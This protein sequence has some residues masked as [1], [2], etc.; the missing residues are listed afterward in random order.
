M[1][2]SLRFSILGPLAVEQDGAPIAI[3]GRRQRALLLRLLLARGR[4]VAASRLI[5]DLWGGEP[6][7]SATNTLQTYVSLLRRAFGDK[8]QAVLVRDA[9]GYRLALEPGALDIDRF[10]ELVRRAEK[11]P[12][13]EALA[14]L[15]EALGLWHGPALLDVADE[16]YAQA[17]SVRL[18]E[19]RLAAVEGR[20][21]RLLD[22]GRHAEAVPG[23]EAA[24][25]EQ[26]LR[27][28]LT[29]LLAQALYRSGRQADALRAI[30]RT[31]THLADEL[32]L[33][34]GPELMRLE[35]AILEHHPSLTGPT[36]PATAA[37]PAAAEAS[38]SPRPRCPGT[39]PTARGPPPPCC[40]SRGASRRG[41]TTS[42]DG[43]TSWR[44]CA[45]SG[46]WPPAVP[47]AWPCS[48]ESLASARRGWP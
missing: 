38:P 20:F 18:E 4:S 29:A 48:T 27:E 46:S 36:A 2:T 26:P 28:G 12:P 13:T 45:P 25:A 15:D 40:R 41:A 21:Q 3:S 34:P 10:E 5:D 47:S 32:G 37:A 8:E 33:D 9:G 42:W 43:S 31:R 24:V 11:A 19:L 6:P 16:P 1:G 35:L 30:S 23:L 7:P 44:G 39:C 22:D 17:E 14:L